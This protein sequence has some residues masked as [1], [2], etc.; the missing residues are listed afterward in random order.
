[1]IEIPESFVAGVIARKGDAGRAW[2]AR[3]P[4]LVASFLA[5]WRCTPTGPALG[6]VGIVIPVSRFDGTPAVLKIS[7]PH[8]GN[9][10]EA[11]AFAAWD[12]RGAALL[13]ER[14]D[15]HFAMLIEQAEWETLDSV[16]SVHE[17]PALIGQLA[18]GPFPLG[19]AWI[20]RAY[21]SIAELLIA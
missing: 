16:G 20:V 2:V 4:D 18:R 10:Q 7:F 17:A 14:D 21:S 19:H 13:Y 12:G 11:H 1:V 15:A 9:P 8:P 3:L 5:R 6:G